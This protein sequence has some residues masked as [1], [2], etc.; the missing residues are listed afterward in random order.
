MQRHEE[1]YIIDYA[2]Y[3][4][5][6]AR[7][8]QVL[9]PDSHGK[10]GSYVITSLYYDDPMDTALLEKQD[11]LARHTKFRLRTYDFSDRIIRLERKVKEGILTQKQSAAITRD[12]LI[13]LDRL[14]DDLAVQMRSG[15]LRPAVAVRYRRDAYFYPGTDLRLTFDTDLRVLPPDMQT[16]FDPSCGG[17]PVLEGGQVIM[18]IKYGSY[19]PAFLR[20]L[21]AVPC[22]QLSVSKYA[23]CREKFR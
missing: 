6:K 1:K 12:Q 5:L 4:R 16:L 13:S 22:Q 17:I 14:D 19:L 20:T 2:W 10:N 9:T 21:T 11:G 3:A 18:E 23:L 8:E 7:A 15:G